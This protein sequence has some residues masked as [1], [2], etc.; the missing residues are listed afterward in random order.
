MTIWFIVIGFIYAVLM[1]VL[2][3][4]AYDRGFKDGQSWV[5]FKAIHIDQPHLN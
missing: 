4:R 3:T 1:A 2:T 5:V